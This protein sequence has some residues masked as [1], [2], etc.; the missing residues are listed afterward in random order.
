VY[1]Q[2]GVAED[3]IP[4]AVPA[5]PAQA[6]AAA[7]AAAPSYLVLLVCAQ[8]FVIIMLLAYSFA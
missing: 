1:V 8:F 3:P 6:H 4:A 7:E 2:D 5:G